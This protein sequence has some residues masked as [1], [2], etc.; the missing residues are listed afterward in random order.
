MFEMSYG[1]YSESTKASQN[2]SNEMKGAYYS[3]LVFSS[4]IKIQ[5][6]MISKATSPFSLS[7]SPKVPSNYSNLSPII[8][9]YPC[10]LPNHLTEKM[11]S[12]MDYC[13]LL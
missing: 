6:L 13:C 3:G 1:T 7:S 2:G 5:E 12:L 9:T 11:K 8:E 4:T 10:L